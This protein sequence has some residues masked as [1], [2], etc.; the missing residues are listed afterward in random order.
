MARLDEDEV[1]LRRDVSWAE[2]EALLA[3]KGDSSAPRIHYL[4]GV[5]EVVTPS[6]GH[7]RHGAWIGALVT[8]YALDQ[9]IE[10]SS[11]RSWLLKDEVRSAGAEP[12]DCY[13]LGDD[14]A[15]PLTRPHFVIEVQWSKRDVNKLE[16][17]RRLDVREVWF[18]ERGTIAVYLLKRGRFVRSTRS[19]C[20]P[21]LDVGLLATF[22]DRPTMTAAI[23]DY[24]AGLAASRGRA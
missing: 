3:R 22:L 6:R 1:E 4:D 10:L 17:Y 7:E 2:L 11:Y 9:G 12:D 24:R 8:A 16:V 15:E 21:D 18:W 5:L 20:L 13:I 19:A 23:R 14:S